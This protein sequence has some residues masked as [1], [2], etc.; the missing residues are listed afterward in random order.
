MEAERYRWITVKERGK[1][2]WGDFSERIA[3]AMK[4]TVR[5][6]TWRLSVTAWH[7]KKVGIG[8]YWVIMGLGGLIDQ[9][10]WIISLLAIHSKKNAC[11]WAMYYTRHHNQLHNQLQ[12]FFYKKNSN[13][14]TELA[15]LRVNDVM[16]SLFL[17]KP[18]NRHQGFYRVQSPNLLY[19]DW[20]N[21]LNR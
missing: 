3:T 1:R 14:L 8:S 18:Y 20:E 15:I 4:T 11:H 5:S 12:L 21:H 7:M 9:L 17:V 2:E 10:L 13:T 6:S 16:I 19:S